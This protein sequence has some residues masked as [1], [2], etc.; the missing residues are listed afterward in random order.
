[1]LRRT[2]ATF[3][4]PERRTIGERAAHLGRADRATPDPSADALPTGI[5]ADWFAAALP[6]VRLLLTGRSA[7]GKPSAP[8]T[9]PSPAE[10]LEPAP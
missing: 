4:G 6:T 1:L 8:A 5:A 10:S 2:F 3:S 7:A 9:Q